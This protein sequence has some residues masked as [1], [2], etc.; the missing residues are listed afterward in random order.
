MSFSP[1][2][3]QLAIIEAATG[4]TDNLLI[5]ALAGAAKTSTLVLVAQA[6]PK[7]NILCLAF[8]KKI[9]EEMKERLP[10][11]CTSMTLNSLGHRAWADAVGKRLNLK[12]SKVFDLISEEISALP[13][14]DRQPLYDNL[15]FL[16]NSV[17]QSKAAGHIPDNYG[18]KSARLCDDAEYFEGLDEVASPLE[19]EVLLRVIS[20]S[21]DL[22]FEGVV[23]FNDQLLMPTVFRASFPPFSLILVDEAQDLSALN[24]AMLTKLVRR[25]IIA[26]GDQA[27]AIYAFRGAHEEGMEALKTRFAM[28]ELP[29]SC[30]FRCPEAIVSH[31]RWRVPSMTWW[32][33]NPTQGEVLRPETLRISDF[34]DDCAIIC[35]NNAPLFGLAIRFLKA[36]RYPNLWGNDIGKG[37]LKVMEKLGPKNLRQP[38]AL[39]ALEDYHAAKAKRVKGKKA[40]ADK[41]ECIRVFLLSSDTLGAAIAYAEHVFRSSGRVNLM[42]AHKSKGAEFN[43]VYFL[44]EFLIGDEEQE[45]NL[46]YV[47]CTRAKRTL[48]YINSE[49]VIA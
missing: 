16:L 21:L 39:R 42:T 24:H 13:E 45:R 36:G 10:A 27:Q 28:R 46:R 34:P 19:Q 44:D 18:R 33:G 2:P 38:D 12:T 30:S 43:N 23:D 31:V 20:R 49:G 3:E 9:A 40:L 5:S 8:N 35:R 48:T 17:G 15:G 22:A 29:L 26:V 47:A 25:R 41:V 14:A 32:A 37:L 4:T 11:N 1:T 6:L 7:V